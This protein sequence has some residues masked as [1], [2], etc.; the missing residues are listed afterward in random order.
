MDD[1]ASYF[2][3][4]AKQA[5]TTKRGKFINYWRSLTNSPMVIK[6]IEKDHKGSTRSEDGIRVTGS[7]QFIAAVCQRLKDILIFEN[8]KTKVDITYTRS[9]LPKDNG[10]ASYILYIN[11]HE[12]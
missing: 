2:K 4:Q 7:P 10:E 12:R 6:P 1:F 9:T 8:P 3:Q 5:K 11:V